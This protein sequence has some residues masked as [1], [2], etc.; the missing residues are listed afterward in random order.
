MT[1]HIHRGLPVPYIAP[2]DTEP[3]LRPPL[4]RRRGRNGQWILCYRDETPYD[5]DSFGALWTRQALARGRGVP[6]FAAVHA[7]R[8]RQAMSRLL[9]QVCG[10]DTLTDTPDRQL[11]IMADTG[12]PVAEGELTTSPPVCLP[13]ARIAVRM[14]PHLRSGH[15]AAW[16]EL[17]QAWGVYGLQYDLTTLAPVDTGPIEVGYDD[18]RIQWT[19]AARHVSIL[20]GV[21]PIQLDELAEAAPAG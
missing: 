4:A 7:L 9:C 17:P 1:Q 2:W 12:Q 13:C 15:V 20:R 18:A 5:R 21:T 11:H 8:Q 14:C 19:I 16:V 6:D 3:M 10:R